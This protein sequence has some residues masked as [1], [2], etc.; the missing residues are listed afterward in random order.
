MQRIKSSIEIQMPGTRNIFF[1]LATICILVSVSFNSS[2]RIYSFKDVSIPDS[3]K[4]VKVNFI[5][6]RAPYVNPQLSQRLTEKLRQKIV[7]QT[8]LNQTNSDDAHYDI[9]GYISDYSVSTAGVSNQ[10][11]VSDRLTVSVHITLNK[12]LSNITEEFDVSR[13]FDFPATSSLQQAEAKLNDQII[14]NI[15]DE[16]FNRVFSNW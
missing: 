12:R 9:S 15:T 6:N 13:S 5:E 2:C 10:Q 11:A 8:R 7:N 1:L 4:T 16:I 14:Q 3:I